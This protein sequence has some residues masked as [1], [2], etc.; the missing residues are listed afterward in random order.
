[1]TIEELTAL[2]EERGRAIYEAN[3][4]ILQL[5]DSLNAAT[6][7]RGEARAEVAK[8][9]KQLSSARECQ[10]RSRLSCNMYANQLYQVSMM[11]GANV[12]DWRGTLAHV[13]DYIAKSSRIQQERDE[14]R[15]EVERLT[16]ER[17]EL[18]VRVAD[19]GAEWTRES[20]ERALREIGILEEP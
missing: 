14:A 6:R 18:I 3:C 10:E 17:D 5:T 8:L 2:C 4:H 13:A 7:E 11:C 16:Y 19:K 12:D 9:T 1:M 20:A 15:A